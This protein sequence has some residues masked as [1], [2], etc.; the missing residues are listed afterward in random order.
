MIKKIKNFLLEHSI[1]KPKHMGPWIRN[2]YFD[3]YFKQKINLSKIEKVLDAGC[4]RGAYANKLANFFKKSKITAVDIKNF[5]EWENYKQKNLAFRKMDLRGL[6]EKNFYDLIISIDSLEHIPHNKKVLR[7]L[8]N[9]LNFLGFLYLAVPRE[10]NVKHF[11]PKRWF[12]SFYQWAEHEHIGE[13]YDLDELKNILKKIGFRII[14]SRYT[15][16]FW[17]NLAWEIEFLLREKSGRLNILMTPLLK[18]LGYLD[19]FL[20]INK[21]NNLIIAQKP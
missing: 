21:G 3:F 11:F 14:F 8:F 4:G 5:L 10:K 15:F 16:T 12:K 13:Q 17:G 6:K 20:P 1:F 9:A 7:N 18:F 19:L 2:L